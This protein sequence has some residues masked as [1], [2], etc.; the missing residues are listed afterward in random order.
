MGQYE[1]DHPNYEWTGRGGLLKGGYTVCWGAKGS[2][3]TTYALFQTGKIQEAGGV[4][5]YFNSEWALDP[6]WAAKQ[7]V[8]LDE[9]F[10]WEGGTL[11]HS[12]DSMIDVVDKGLIDAVIVDT[13]HAFGLQADFEAGSGKKRTIAD[14]IPQGRLA[15][16][17]SRFFRVAT[18]K[19]GKG[20][21]A[22]LLIGQARAKDEWEQLTGGHALHHYNSCNLHFIRIE[23]RDKVPSMKVPNPSGKGSITKPIGF[24]MKVVAEKTR[25]NHREKD[26]I[27]LPFLWGKGIDDFETNIMAAVR[28][29][30]IKQAGSFYTLPTADGEVKL[31]GKAQLLEWIQVNHQYYEWLMDW[32]TG[33]HK[34]SPAHAAAVDKEAVEGE[35]KKKKDKKEKK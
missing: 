28:L 3:K 35:P 4:V 24:L 21:I 32:L 5:G 1:G 14:E 18:A 27:I 23:A 11:E 2:G 29:G 31:Q 13:I 20:E 12:L 26:D 10:I 7:M 33:G 17:L 8:N 25:I 9:L 19:V 30:L 15:A 16:K 22:A 34:D 6:I